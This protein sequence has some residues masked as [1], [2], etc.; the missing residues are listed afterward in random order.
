MDIKGI[1]HLSLDEIRTEVAHGAKFVYF[2]Y[3]ISLIIITFRRPSATYFVRSRESAIKYGWPFFLISL[4][5]GW[6]G[7]PW[8]PVYTIGALFG[9]FKGKNLT[10]EIMADLEA[11]YAQEHPITGWD[12]FNNQA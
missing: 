11:Q 8:G 1:E 2:T 3:C 5:F 6:W 9:A 4:I 10:N 7:I 12:Q